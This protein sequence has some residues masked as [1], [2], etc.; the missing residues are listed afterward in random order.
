MIGHPDGARLLAV[1]RA[2]SSAR[3]AARALVLAEGPAG[4]LAACCYVVHVPP[5]LIAEVGR[6]RRF[7]RACP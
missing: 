6:H 5:A 3:G 2:L 7:I 4:P 1:A